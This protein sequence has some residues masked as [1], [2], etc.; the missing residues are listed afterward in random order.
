MQHGGNRK[1]ARRRDGGG[2]V[3]EPREP[4]RAIHPESAQESNLADGGADVCRKP[5][6][7]G[8]H[9]QHLA[10]W[11]A[12]AGRHEHH[13]TGIREAEYRPRQRVPKRR[14]PP[15]GR[16]RSVPALPPRSAL[17]NEEFSDAGNPNFLPRRRGGGDGEKVTRQPTGLCPTLLCG[18]LDLGPPRR[19]QH[20]RDR[21]HHEQDERR[22][23]R[24]QQ[25]HRHAQPQNPP[26]RGKQGHVHVVEHKHL[27]AEH[28]EPIEILRAF[29][30]RDGRDRSLQLCDMRLESDGHLVAEAALHACADRA[31]KPRCGGRHAKANRR[32]FHNAGSV[33]QNAFA[34]QHQPQGKER[35]GQRRELRQHERHDHQARLMAIPQLAQPPHRRQCGRQR[36]NRSRRPGRAIPIRR[37][38]HRSC[39]PPRLGR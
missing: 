30:M 5:R 18:S 31:E 23:N 26:E 2:V 14:A 8:E 21:E 19:R 13:R 15:S 7:C 10:G 6:T 3:L 17:C 16:H 36:V 29:L 4:P 12:E 39:P 28:G 24:G 38:L 27:I 22:V 33:L 35:I 9:Q 34:E 20:G 32:T 37:G 11:R 1:I 25:R